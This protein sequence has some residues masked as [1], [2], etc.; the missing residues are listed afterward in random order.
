VRSGERGVEEDGVI[1][2]VS[3]VALRMASVKL[4]VMGSGGVG[5]SSVTARYICGDYKELY[6]PTVE[7][8]YNKDIV[9]DGKHIQLQILDT[10]GQDEYSELR[11]TF[12]HTGQGFVLVFSIDDDS[13]FE[14]LR[15]IRDDILRVHP[16]KKV[17][18]ILVGNKCDLDDSRAVT[19][20]E[21]KSMA[22]RFK[23][24]YKE[25]SAKSDLNIDELFTSFTKQILDYT[26]L[27]KTATSAAASGSTKTSMRRDPT[28]G[29]VLGAGTT[30]PEAAIHSKK[31]KSFLSKRPKCIIS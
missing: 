3:P 29:G 7:D 1:L 31:K 10:A 5:K 24:E 27:K 9:M 28:T 11:E 23:C 16:D 13:T 2:V 17:P 15:D 22:K 4:I 20:Q 21:A 6:D 26:E 30:H 18:L 8:S 12:L 19:Q 25:V 14:A